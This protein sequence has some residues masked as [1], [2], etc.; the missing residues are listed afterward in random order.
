MRLADALV[1]I[2]GRNV[3]IHEALIV[4]FGVT[5]PPKIFVGDVR[6][7]ATPPNEC[8]GALYGRFRPL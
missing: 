4:L 1:I 5:M 2:F 8:A 7:L 6:C 3:T